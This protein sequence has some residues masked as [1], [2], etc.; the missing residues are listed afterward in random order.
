MKKSEHAKTQ[1][2]KIPQEFGDE[3]KLQ[4]YAHN[5]WVYF[6]CLRGAYGLPQSGIVAKHLRRSRLEKEG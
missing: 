6:E 4:K 1:C 2:S 5:G 3:Y